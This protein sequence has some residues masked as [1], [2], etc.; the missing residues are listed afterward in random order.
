M[1]MHAHTHT[2]THTCARANTDTHICTDVWIDRNI[3]MNTVRND[4]VYLVCGYCLEKSSVLVIVTTPALLIGFVCLLLVDVDG[5]CLYCTAI[6]W[7]H[8]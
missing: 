4:K 7:E 2:H 8:H 1:C 6:F 3:L 5:Q